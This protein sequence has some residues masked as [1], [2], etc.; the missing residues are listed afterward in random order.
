M[1][2]ESTESKVA[3]LQTV[4]TLDTQDLWALSLQTPQLSPCEVTPILR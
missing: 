1:Q 2:L 3:H 4:R